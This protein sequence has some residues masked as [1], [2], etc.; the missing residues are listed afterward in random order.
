[1]TTGSTVPSP[2]PY[3]IPG[4]PFLGAPAGADLRAADEVPDG[5]AA[6]Y[7][8]Q[9]DAGRVA[10]RYRGWVG[11]GAVLAVLA[12]GPGVDVD[13]AGGGARRVRDAEGA[14]DTDAHRRGR[15]GTVPGG[16][17][18]RAGCRLAGRPVRAD[19]AGAVYLCAG[20]GPH[21]DGSGLWA[22]GDGAGAAA[23]SG[24]DAPRHP[25]DVAGTQGKPG[26][27]GDR[28]AGH[29]G[30]GGGVRGAAGR[31]RCPV[32]RAGHGGAAVHVR[33]RHD[34]AGHRRGAGRRVRVGGHLRAVDAAGL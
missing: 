6:R 22:T 20:A 4:A 19:L 10:Q 2:Y 28:R 12:A 11:R 30:A 34:R 21:L 13:R 26:S 3:P 31:C 1:M 23:G 15:A 25:H 9:D 7:P 16:G 5:V 33:R 32:P 18:D 24:V 29:G 17:A 14:V 8:V 27:G